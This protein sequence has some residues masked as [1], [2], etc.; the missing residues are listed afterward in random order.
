MA[1]P[2][3]SARDASTFSKSLDRSD[4]PDAR[5]PQ[6]AVTPARNTQEDEDDESPIPMRRTRKG[7]YVQESE[8]SPK[9]T[10]QNV[11]QSFVQEEDVGHELRRT[12]RSRH[13]PVRFGN[14]VQEFSLDHEN[15]AGKSGS[16]AEPPAKRQATWSTRSKNI[17]QA[18][19]SSSLVEIDES[20][21]ADE[22]DCIVH[23]PDHGRFPREDTPE[24]I[25]A[26][27]LPR[28]VSK[29]KGG[30]KPVPALFWGGDHVYIAAMLRVK[31]L[32]V[33]QELKKQKQKSKG[34]KRKRE[35]ETRE[36]WC[37][38]KK[39]DDGSQMIA[40]EDPRCTVEWFHVGCL[41][42][43]EY[44]LAEEWGTQYIRPSSWVSLLTN[45]R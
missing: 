22:G 44:E 10:V 38:C 18:T 35:S 19:S 31:E 2:G 33:Q 1:Q 43:V 39:P 23:D 32:K 30:D 21:S 6:R 13:A 11:Q 15:T 40:C 26:P 36:T 28:D 34:T 20:T 42:D 29:F 16:S 37:R 17:A 3:N 27:Q 12:R 8:P 7:R 25:P 24:P 5:S 4:N 45:Y 41:D 14:F 9:P